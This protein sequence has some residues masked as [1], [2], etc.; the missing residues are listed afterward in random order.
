MTISSEVRKAGPYDGND[1]TTAF[2]FSFKVF[3][4]D[5]VAVVLTDPA[6]IE[7][8]L[9]GN[10]T[11]YSVT[12][13]ADQDTAP[14]GTVNKVSAL[15]TDYLL[16]ITSSVPNLQ[17][18][19]L[20]NQGGFYPKVI[21]A[22]LD[23][24][25]ILAQ[26]LDEQVGR[27]VKVP[28]SS[29]L[30]PDQLIA[31]LYSVKAS[32]AESATSS[33][34]SAAAAALYASSVND[35]RIAAEAARDALFNDL[36]DTG[37]GKGADLVAYLPQ[38]TGAVPTSVQEYLRKYPS[39]FGFGDQGDGSDATSKLQN[40]ITASYGKKLTIHS[41]THLITGD[42]LS[43]TS[44]IH[45]VG[46]P[47]T[48]LKL[49]SSA[50]SDYLINLSS[51][52]ADDFI[53]EG[54][55][56]DLNQPTTD[57]WTNILVRVSAASRVRFVRCKFINSASS[58]FGAANNGYGA[59]LNGAY[60]TVSFEGC[61]FERHR[62]G[63]ITEPSSTGN[64]VHIDAACVFYEMAGDG[65]E[66]NVPTGSCAN[67]NVIGATFKRIGSNSVGRGFGVGASGGVGTTIANLKVLG[68]SFYECDNQ[69]IHIE[70]GCKNVKILGNYISGCGTA[71]A[72]S[73]GSGIYLA[74]G[75]AANRA[76]SDLTVDGNTIIGAPGSDYGIFAAGTYA[77]GIIN[78][79]NNTVDCAGSC[80]G[81]AVNSVDSQ[82][83]VNNNKIKNSNGVGI[84]YNATSGSLIGNTCWDDQGVKTQTYGIE[85]QSNACEVFVRDNNLSGNI[86]KGFLLS[87]PT[88]PK[89]V[90]SDSIRLTGL[91][92][93]AVAYS[94]WIDVI[95]LGLAASGTVYV[96]AVRS[97]DRSTG[98]FT[99]SWDGT[100]LT[101]SKL[102]IQSSGN[103]AIS[104]TFASAL[105]VTSGWLQTEIYNA[106]A[107]L[108]DLTLEVSFDGSLLLK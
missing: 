35:A 2:P 24:L 1:V 86:N 26:Q 100:T 50:N 78:V 21:N 104:G 68:A 59:Y 41:G 67:V 3:S 74:A 75:V 102:N 36:A 29:G 81:I 37:A 25:T 40:A 4:A 39:V 93:G 103:L 64:G 95:Y 10:G 46:E 48:I 56:F 63:V 8:T 57:A 82:T 84:R 34:A 73:F 85:L 92:A 44:G 77:A 11:D 51:A 13:N 105:R 12:L 76:I 9:T 49:A 62:Y 15:A 20:T 94:A 61:Y 71:A 99:I 19:D 18:L 91:S 90:K 83:N 66:I 60:D 38:G 27:A 22:A 16:T 52:A 72:T 17:P 87:S 33:E 30:T 69:G 58:A 23:R 6:G 70:D 106:G 55:T 89:T 98:L 65:V 43:A 97:S 47:G 101:G 108:S 54:I 80:R 31:D 28:I 107:A 79:I 32:A 42:T 5:D 96:N 14:G 53:F 7:T 45:I 88:F